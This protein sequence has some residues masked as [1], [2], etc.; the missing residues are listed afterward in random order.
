MN[1]GR[2]FDSWAEREAAYASTTASEPEVTTVPPTNE[3]LD[4]FLK[5]EIEKPCQLLSATGQECDRPASWLMIIRPG[6]KCG[7]EVLQRFAC[8]RCRRRA[9]GGGVSCKHCGVRG[10]ITW[11]E[12]MR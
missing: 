12:R 1:W 10:Q 6:C 8:A 5:G 2:G 3:E 9:L 11:T 4:Q 7:T